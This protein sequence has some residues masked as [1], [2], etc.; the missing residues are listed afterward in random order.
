LQYK[1]KPT[2]PRNVGTIVE[3]T[4]YSN[5]KAMLCNAGEK[6]GIYP[7]IAPFSTFLGVNILHGLTPS[8]QVK[9]KLSTS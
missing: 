1:R 7:E 2:D 9:M 5:T 8:P 4:T 3:W 6:G